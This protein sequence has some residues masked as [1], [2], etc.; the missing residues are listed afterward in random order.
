M[1]QLVNAS[2][3]VAERE[4][5]YRDRLLVVTRGSPLPAGAL[6][7]PSGVNFVL[8]SRHATAVWLVLVEPYDNVVRAEIPL[9]SSFNRTGDHWHVRID[10]LP[11]V[12]GYGY[13]VDGPKGIGDRFDPT[14]VLHDPYARALTCGQPWAANTKMPR[15][16]LM[17]D[18]EA[19]RERPVYPRTALED[20]IIYELHVRGFTASPSSGVRHPG[21]YAGLAEKIDY[22]KALGATAIE[23]LPV[24]EFDENDCPFVNPLTGERL[25]NYW[26]YAP[27][28]FCAPKAAYAHNHELS[29]PWAEFRAMVD[30][31]HEA[32]LEIYLDV[33]FNHTAEGGEN[34]PTYCFRGLDN[35]LYYML[36]ANGKYLNFSGCGN[37][38]SNDHPVVRN[39]VLH[40]L[41]N[42]VAE[43]GVDGF[44]FDLASILGR[45]RRGNPVNEPPVVNRISED[46]LLRDAKLIAEP[47]DA[48]GLYQVGTFPGHGR[49]S[50]WNGRFRDD[51]RR[52]WRGD[53]DM[54]SELASRICGSDDLYQGR[55]PLDSINFITCHDGFT[56]LDLVSYNQKHNEPNG[57]GNHDGSDV[58]WSWNCGAEGP[59]DNSAVERLRDRQVRNLMATLLIS[60]GVPMILA[61]DELLRTQIGNNN[62]W[63]QDNPTSWIDWTPSSRSLEFLRFVRM[64]IAL[65]KA[66]VVL[67]RRTFFKAERA[68][69]PPPILWHGVQPS[70]PDFSSGS[71][72]IAFALDGRRSDRAGVVDC[73]IYVAM[74]AYRNALTFTIPAAP[75]GRAWRRVVDTALPSPEDIVEE[76]H[77][78]RVDVLQ[79][80]PVQAHSMIV[81]VS[82]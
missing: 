21:T 45:D 41:R 25:R 43:G 49:W 55:N 63:C 73:D 64:M 46:S 15:R 40:C 7:T 26:G 76:K 69:Q 60:Q 52:F 36:D 32:A 19:D 27:I 10:G 9:D 17:I 82:E 54:T 37:T 31:F 24:D 18:L 65:R 77:A 42:W 33:V 6:P 4:H 3:E 35:A 13:R 34:G 44:R 22:I 74:N 56:L 72:S 30:A 70:N 58:N 71:H 75:S 67:R 62:A 29:G 23:L 81:L 28:A 16:S 80:Y 66:H 2:A 47:W 38:F 79:K 12:F 39:Y 20:T 5:T 1:T 48:G 68:G 61:G 57:E 50:D 11:E 14:R 53:S 78:P 51:V 59:S 8:I